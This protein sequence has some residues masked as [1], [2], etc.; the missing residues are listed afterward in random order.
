VAELVHLKPMK[1]P[2][3]KSRPLFFTLSAVVV[4]C[5]AFV[6]HSKTAAPQKAVQP[7]PAARPAA[8]GPVDSSYLLPVEKWQNNKF[9]VLAKPPMFRKFGYELYLTKKLSA[10]TAALDTATEA[11]KHH[12]RYSLMAGKTLTVTHVEKADGEYLVTFSEEKSGRTVFARTHKGAIEGIARADDLDSAARKWVGKT[13]Y[14]RRRFIDTYDSTTGAYGTIK[15]RI[16]DNL[17]VTGV[18]WGRSPL[19]PKPVWLH[20]ETPAHEKGFIPVCMSW[21][22]VMA[23]KITPGLSWAEEL[24]ETNPV[25]LYRWDS[26]T[27]VAINGHTIVSGMNKEQVLV[28][29]GQPHKVTMDTAQLRCPEQWLFGSQYLCFDHDTVISVGAR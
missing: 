10:N 21:A 6:I 11:D 24:F 16:Q 2:D 17:K 27:W 28:S 29:W 15:V 4:V 26:L 20:V 9:F 3:K 13:V 7:S 12:A 19:P 8:S 22:N 23:D 5:A 18:T 1:R 14:S 25:S